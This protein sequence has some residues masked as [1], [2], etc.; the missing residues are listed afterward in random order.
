MS[1]ENKSKKEWTK[2]FECG[3]MDS[4][5]SARVAGS[6]EPSEPDEPALKEDRMKLVNLMGRDLTVAGFTIPVGEFLAK[7]PNLNKSINNNLTGTLEIDGIGAVPVVYPAPSNFNDCILVRIGDTSGTTLPFPP[8]IE[9]TIYVVPYP[10]RVAARASGRTDVF[11]V[12]E[13]NDPSNPN[14]GAKSLAA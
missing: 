9:G 1:R 8:A 5:G 2:F 13:L 14:A 10:V 4:V 12:G 3:K 11:G 7:A 6:I